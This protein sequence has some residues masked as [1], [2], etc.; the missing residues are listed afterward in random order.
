M[1]YKI[2]LSC[3]FMFIMKQILE[4]IQTVQILEQFLLIQ[5]NYNTTVEKRY[6][7]VKTSKIRIF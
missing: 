3:Y 4:R 6:N 5:A 1:S 2:H 7:I